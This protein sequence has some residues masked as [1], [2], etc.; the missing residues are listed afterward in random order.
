[1]KI[2]RRVELILINNKLQKENA[3]LKKQIEDIKYLDRGKLRNLIFK[4]PADEINEKELINNICKLALPSEEKIMGKDK[5]II[6]AKGILAETNYLG[7]CVIK[8]VDGKKE[9]GVIPC[10]IDVSDLHK[11]IGKSVTI[12]AVIEDNK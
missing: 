3:E 5:E 2:C 8:D 7:Y 4:Y 9:I 12:K 1:M 6:L 11:Y 10:Q